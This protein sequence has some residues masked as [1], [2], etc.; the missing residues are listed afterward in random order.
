MDVVLNCVQ[1]KG[2]QI[3]LAEMLADPELVFT[4]RLY[5]PVVAVLIFFSLNTSGF[6]GMVLV[7]G[8][9]LPD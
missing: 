5:M 8:A 9:L 6:P 1:K 7:R 4:Q 2:I 3:K